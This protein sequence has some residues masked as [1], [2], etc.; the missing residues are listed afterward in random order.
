MSSGIT[1]SALYTGRI[2][3][4]RFTQV[5][6]ILDY[7]VFMVF[8]DLD[9]IESVMAQSSLWSINRLALAQF[10]TQD[11][12]AQNQSTSV[13]SLK[14]NLQHAFMEATGEKPERI[15]VLT[16][17]RYFGYLIN[18]V[19]FYYG[20]DANGQLI[21]TLAEITNTPW[22]QRFHYTL[23]ATATDNNQSS[24][25][26][27]RVSEKPNSV[28][29]E[30]FFDKVFHV[31]P[32]HPMALQYRWLMQDPEQQLLIHMDN[33]EGGHKIFDATLQLQ[34]QS[35]TKKSMHRVLLHY[36]VMTLKVLA[37][38]YWNAFLLWIKRSPFYS[39]PNNDPKRDWQ[40]RQPT[41]KSATDSIKTTEVSS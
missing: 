28:M 41:T 8:L 1:H 13:Q 35:I 18:P 25:L 21:A 20:Y 36:P 7:R 24:V 3:H 22:D 17:M 2:R 11:Y 38:I 16:N 29:R 10:K 15:C 19:S 37:G 12:F 14:Q 9:E 32:F 6:H 26:P 4:R 39:H 34:R 31:S 40:Q 23:A 33:L 5:H 30:Y 27:Q